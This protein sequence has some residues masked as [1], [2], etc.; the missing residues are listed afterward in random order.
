MQECEFKKVALLVFKTP[1][2]K[3]TS[4]RQRLI[5]ISSLRQHVC[6]VEVISRMTVILTNFNVLDMNMWFATVIRVGMDR[7][8]RISCAIFSFE[9]NI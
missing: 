1:F 4:G 8:D 7:Q 6:E 2:H 3:K 5:T 9:W